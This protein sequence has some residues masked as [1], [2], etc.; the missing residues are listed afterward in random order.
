MTSSVSTKGP[1]SLVRLVLFIAAIGVGVFLAGA[2]ALTTL[3]MAR[4]E[5]AAEIYR[6]RLAGLSSEYESLRGQYNEAVARTAV[7]E[8]L[9][10]GEDLAIRVRTAQ[11]VERTIETPFNPN[12]E[13]YVDYVVLNGRLWIRRVFDAQTPPWAGLVIDPPLEKVDWTSQTASV[14]KAVYRSL[15][16]GRWIVTV[17]GDGSLGLAKVDPNATVRLAPPPEVRDYAQVEK[18]VEEATRRVRMADVWREML[19]PDPVDRR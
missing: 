5:V 4:N 13:I 9:V 1:V 17:T 2:V 7:T 12:I 14:G 11:G 19:D 16:D 10:D 8:L 18:E 3:R 15:S 6:D